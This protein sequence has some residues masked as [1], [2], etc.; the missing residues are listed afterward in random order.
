MKIRTETIIHQPQESFDIQRAQL[1]KIKNLLPSSQAEAIGALAVPMIG[2]PEVDLMVISENISNDS[3]ILVKNG[4]K[5]GPVV[6]GIS[7]LKMM[8]GGVEVAI[9]I[10]PM[11]HRMI[12]IHR[13]IIALLRRDGELR[14]KYEDF[15]STLSGLSGEEYKERKS[16]WIKDNI[17]PLL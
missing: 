16:K 1:E 3:D 10:I 13:K 17:K 2:R 15:K 7:F 6:D 5:Q 9:Q 4:Y 14:K 11:G 12:D 8:V